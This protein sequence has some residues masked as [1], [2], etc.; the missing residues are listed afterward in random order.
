MREIGI[1]FSTSMIQS[2]QEDRKSM[3]RRIV[4]KMLCECGN[5]IPHEVCN[6]TFEGF[7]TSGHSGLWSCESC[8]AEPVKCPYGIPGDILLPQETWK[9]V[10]KVDHDC[11]MLIEYKVGG[12]KVVRFTEE[13]YLKFRKFHGKAGWQSP[14]FMPKE[15]C[16]NRLLN[17]GVKVERLQDITEE[18]AKDEGVKDPYDY[19][20]PEYYEQ[21][22]VRGLEINKSAFAGLWDSLNKNPGYSWQANPWV[23]VVSFEKVTP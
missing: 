19:Q 22:C 8:M 11:M 2:I 18:D 16:R 23:W 10:S 12:T 4:K 1:L 20:P 9:V 14:Y 21:P 7:Q 5:W 17:K 6:T 13:R 3:T 15:A